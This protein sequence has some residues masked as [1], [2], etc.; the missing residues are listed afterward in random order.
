ITTEVASG[1]SV[2]LGL[3]NG[4]FGP[5]T[6]VAFDYPR[7]IA[8][9]DVTGD[10]I[11]DLVVSDYYGVQ[12]LRG[13]GDGTFVSATSYPS[14]QYPGYPGAIPLADLNGDGRLDIAVAHRMD[15]INGVVAVRLATA[16]GGFSDL[17]QD[18]GVGSVPVAIA[19]ADLNHD[20]RPDLVVANVGR[21]SDSI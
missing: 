18:F 11:P 1:V 4:T 21:Y 15:G 6:V 10:G 14:N 5:R 17:S 2:L 12:V 8:A 3:G 20:D 16:S 7:G 19:I 9:G 13:V